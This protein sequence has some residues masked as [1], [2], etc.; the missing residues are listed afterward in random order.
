MDTVLVRIKDFCIQDFHSLRVGSFNP[1]N[2][3]V[4][5]FKD[6]DAQIFEKH[7]NSV[8]LVFIG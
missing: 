2:G 6:K 8:M 3:E 4:T 5:F 7:L 1:S